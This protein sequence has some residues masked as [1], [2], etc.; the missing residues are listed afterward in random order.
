MQRKVCRN[1]FV[2]A[3]CDTSVCVCVCVAIKKLLAVKAD[4]MI[5]NHFHKIRFP[6]QRQELVE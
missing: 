5:P 4:R 2:A 1:C 6:L 3:F